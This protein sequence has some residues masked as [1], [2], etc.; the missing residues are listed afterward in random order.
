[1]AFQF[2]LDWQLST[3]TWLA[4]LFFFFFYAS[5]RNAILIFYVQYGSFSKLWE[6]CRKA[7]LLPKHA[8]YIRQKHVFTEVPDF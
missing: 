5:G 4:S 6:I 3:A 2:I 1:M 8:K 7:F